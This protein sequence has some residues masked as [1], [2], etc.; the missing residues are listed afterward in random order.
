MYGI[1]AVECWN[2]FATV[3]SSQEVPT[4][5]ALFIHITNVIWVAGF[6][7]VRQDHGPRSASFGPRTT[8]PQFAGYE[9]HLLLSNGGSQSVPTVLLKAFYRGL[10]SNC[11]IVFAKALAQW[12]PSWRTGR[13]TWG[14]RGFEAFSFLKTTA[15][16]Q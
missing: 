12:N 10:E 14:A 5:S 9:L 16:E 3:G 7:S 1:V 8:S 2:R 15:V 13:Q 11:A 4:H 6:V